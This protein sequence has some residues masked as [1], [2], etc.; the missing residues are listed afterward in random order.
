M[1]DTNN[2][3]RNQKVNTKDMIKLIMNTVNQADIHKNDNKRIKQY[4]IREFLSVLA[5]CM[6][7]SLQLKKSVFLPGVGVFQ[8]RHKRATRRRNP[9]NGEFISVPAGESIKCKLFK[10]FSDKTLNNQ[11]PN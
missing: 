6:S 7:E 8:I 11:K 9:K 2:H 1:Q 3:N 4:Q 10:S 5:K